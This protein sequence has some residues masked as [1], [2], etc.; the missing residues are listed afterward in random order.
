V[1]ACGRIAD[2]IVESISTLPSATRSTP[3]SANSTARSAGGAGMVVLPV[4]I[5]L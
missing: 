3:T 4:R 5:V 1:I 2:I